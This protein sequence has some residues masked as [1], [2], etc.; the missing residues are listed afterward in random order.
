MIVIDREGHIH[1]RT[2]LP[3]A[4]L[5]S[6]I[7]L[8]GGLWLAGCGGPS[9][10]PPS[11]GSPAKPAPKAAVPAP[12]VA[13]PVSAQVVPPEPPYVYVAGNRRD[14]FRSVIVSSGT[15]ETK[16]IVQP[17]QQYAVT[18]LKLVAIVWGPM[19]TS[20]MLQTPDGKGYT[21]RKGATVG[22]RQ[23]VI[24]EI[25]PDQLVVEERFT[26]LFGERKEQTVVLD[27]HPPEEKL[28]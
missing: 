1:A 5:L 28:K 8:L 22:K 14:P 24:K 6:G 25:K 9:P 3:M 12:A 7:A 2:G 13:T 26:D 17:L 11:A 18:E 16:D 23:G 20:A 15:K 21:V 27:L 19:G 4:R 10:A